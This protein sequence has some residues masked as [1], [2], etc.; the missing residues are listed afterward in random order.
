[1][2]LGG[3]IIIVFI[4]SI[5]TV[6]LLDLKTVLRDFVITVLTIPYLGRVKNPAVF[7]LGLVGILGIVLVGIVKLL[8]NGK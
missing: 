7:Y 6:Y 4:I 1:M 3:R 8:K 2:D 5:I